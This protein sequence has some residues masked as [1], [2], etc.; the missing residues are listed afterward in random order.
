MAQPCR[1]EVRAKHALR[2]VAEHGPDKPCRSEVR[3]KHALRSVAKH[4]PDN[5]HAEAHSYPNSGN[6]KAF[7][8]RRPSQNWLHVLGSHPPPPC[9]SPSQHILPGSFLCWLHNQLQSTPPRSQS[10]ALTPHLKVPAMAAADSHLVSGQTNRA[11]LRALPQVSFGEGLCLQAVFIGST[12][13]T[14][15]FFSQKLSPSTL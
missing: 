2:S 1:S 7:P 6:G 12:C 14:R 13:L 8:S 4:G 15:L 5:S 10:G 3:A 9:L 11:G